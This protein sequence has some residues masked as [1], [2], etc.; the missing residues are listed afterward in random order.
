MNALQLARDRILTPSGL[1][2]RR[3]EQAL[4][5]LLGAAVDAGDLYFQLAR[6]EHW[7]LEDGIVKEGSHGIEQGVACARWPAS[8]WPPI[9]RGRAGALPAAVARAQ[10]A[11]G[12]RRWSGSARECAAYLPDDPIAPLWRTPTRSLLTNSIARAPADR[13][14]SRWSRGFART[15]SCWSRPAT[16]RCRRRAAARAA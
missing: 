1:D 13:G 14:S 6:E 7:A 12:R 4:G 5:S 10:C 3:L 16:A 8:D 2:D 11:R 9:R 15:R